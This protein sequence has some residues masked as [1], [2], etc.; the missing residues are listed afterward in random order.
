MKYITD[1]VERLD[2]FL[3]AQVNVSRGRVQRAVKDGLVKVNSQIILEP[4]HRLSVGDSVSAPEFTDEK[5]QPMQYDLKIV[6]ENQD[7]CVIDK[8]ANLVVHPGAGHKQDTLSNALLARYPGVEKVGDPARPGIVHRLDEDTSGLIVAAKTQAGYEYMKNLFI[9]R[10]IQ[11]EYLALV[12]GVPPK[13][14]DTI[15]EPIGRTSTHLKM[16]VGVGKEAVTEYKVLETNE[17]AGGVDKMSLLR[18]KLH[19]GR[20]HQIRAHM[21]HIGNPL[22]GDQIYGGQFKKTDALLTSRQ[23]LHAAQ[24]SFKLPDGTSID[25]G[26]PLPADLQEVLEKVKIKYDA[27]I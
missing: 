2:K 1:R 3:A 15:N 10:N 4:D 8:P 17:Q 21:A 6:F 22:V 11:K 7:I 9:T 13:L 20:T 5:I 27:R 14:H 18:V 12:H 24:L 19:T 16:R 26:S 23:F 25:L